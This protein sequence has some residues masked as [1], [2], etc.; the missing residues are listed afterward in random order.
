MV[1]VV[2]VGG[3]AEIAL[4]LGCV[5]IPITDFEVSSIPVQAA[6]TAH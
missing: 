5:I 2:G 4:V 3:V 1:V 6:N